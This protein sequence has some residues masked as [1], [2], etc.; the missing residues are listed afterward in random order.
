[1]MLG[2]L[3]LSLLMPSFFSSSPEW[4]QQGPGTKIGIQGERGQMAT[5]M[6][7]HNSHNGHL[8]LHMSCSL[9]NFLLVQEEGFKSES[10]L[11]DILTS[12]SAR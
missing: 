9:N 3:Q 8:N 10:R 4:I 6:R 12:P 2:S 11:E 1:M 7:V 5:L